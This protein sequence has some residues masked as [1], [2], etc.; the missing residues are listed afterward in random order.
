MGSSP[1]TIPTRR[2]ATTGTST[3]WRPTGGIALLVEG[4][5]D[6]AL[7]EPPANVLRLS[8]HPDGLAPRIRNLANSREHF[9]RRLEN[10]L[11][12]SG[13]TRLKALWEELLALPAT[14]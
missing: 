5:A 1:L 14:E 6:P 3:W 7:R 2:S 9:L 4:V 13:D 10:D 12:R 11:A 8:L